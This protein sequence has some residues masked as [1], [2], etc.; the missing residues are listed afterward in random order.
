MRS[1][2]RCQAAFE[3]LDL[4]V[5]SAGEEGKDQVAGILQHTG[6]GGEAIGL[7]VVGQDRCDPRL[8]VEETADGQV[9]DGLRGESHDGGSLLDQVSVA[10]E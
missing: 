4:A 8:V 2:S 6:Q 10:A 7:D 9:A 1:I 5:A 3:V